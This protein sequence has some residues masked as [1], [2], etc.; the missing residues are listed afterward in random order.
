MAVDLLDLGFE[1][2]SLALKFGNL[3]LGQPVPLFLDR[4]RELLP[5][6][7]D[8]I[9]IHDTFEGRE[10]LI[11]VLHPFEKLT[12]PFFQEGKGLTLVGIVLQDLLYEL[13]AGVILV[14]DFTP[15]SHSNRDVRAAID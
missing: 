15:C 4:A 9:P 8:M 5:V 3:V 7:F 1:L 6:I 10:P 14:Q 2:L 12:M 11:D 13:K